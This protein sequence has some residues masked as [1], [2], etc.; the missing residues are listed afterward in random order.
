[1]T[2]NNQKDELRNAGHSFDGIEE[3]D[4]DMPRW[5]L[6]LFHVTIVFGFGYLA[7]YHLPF[8]PSKSLIEEYEKT[9]RGFRFRQKKF[10]RSRHGR[11]S[12]SL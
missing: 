3:Y 5:W 2:K 11:P 9:G 10:V 12:R 4:N 7:W 8:F 1:M 6:N